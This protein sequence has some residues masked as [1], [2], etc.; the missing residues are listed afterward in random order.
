M[1]RALP[2]A[3]EAASLLAFALLYLVAARLGHLLTPQP[4]TFATFWPPG[5]LFLAAL[6]VVR[7][8]LMP[9]VVVAV[10]PPSV[11]SNFALGVPPAMTGMFLVSDI[12]AALAAASVIRRVVR[13]RPSLTILW[14]VTVFVG[15]A[16][17]GAAVAALG[18]AVTLAIFGSPL[19]ESF[20]LWWL[21]D[22]LGALIVGSVFLAWSEPDDDFHALTR[23]RAIEATVL[24]LLAVVST[25][26]VFSSAGEHHL[27]MELALIPCLLWAALRFGQRGAT[28]LGLIVSVAAVIGARARLGPLATIPEV[29]ERTLAVQVFLA[30]VIVTQLVVAATVAERRAAAEALRRS[31]EQLFRAEKL[32]GIGR[33]AG[34]IEHDFNNILTIVNTYA[35]HALLA[36]RDE[37][38]RAAVP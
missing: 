8:P 11:A 29:D 9:W 33:L 12:A 31:R 27:P 19:G 15:G 18:G 23:P 28:T 5:G 25:W 20:R 16:V 30:V 36:P 17:G 2:T 24:I 37:R 10:I 35:V 6:L 26:A 32:E 34:G 22:A 1:R 7:R 38:P 13:G 4:R 14:H 3:R 21:G